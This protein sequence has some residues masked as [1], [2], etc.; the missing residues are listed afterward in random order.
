MKRDTKGERRKDFFLQPADRRL[1]RK[2]E[3]AEVL[4]EWGW[5]LKS[6]VK[7]QKNGKT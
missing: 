5:F 4:A 6:R 3:L 1:Q 7:A 2:K